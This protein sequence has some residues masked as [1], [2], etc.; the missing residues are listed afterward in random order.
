M[1]V[2]QSPYWMD[3]RSIVQHC[4][5]WNH[6]LAYRPVGAFPLFDGVIHTAAFFRLF[7][8]GHVEAEAPPVTSCPTFLT[9]VVAQA[10]SA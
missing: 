2:K 3:A 9:G 4:D 6:L 7:A 8:G 1:E 10:K 5:R